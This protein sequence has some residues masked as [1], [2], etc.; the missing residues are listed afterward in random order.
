MTC[1][2]AQGLIMPYINDKL[3]VD[4][5]EEFLT[6]IEQCSD[7]KEEL[8][9]Y[10]TLLTG[11][12]QLDEDKNLSGNLHVDFEKSLH[13]SEERIR[14]TRL[15]YVRKRMIY[16]MIC[17]AFCILVNTNQGISMDKEPVEE[18][19]EESSY[20]NKYYYY[21]DRPTVLKQELQKHYDSILEFI[22]KQQANEM[23]EIV[24]PGKHGE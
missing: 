2:E 20:Y 24:Y 13:K 15:N 8:E 10:F 6:H 22:A 5:L 4:Q 3:D 11:M 12:K 17:F 23:K 7:C 18:T 1:K 16:V 21:M 14:K 9:V 19:I